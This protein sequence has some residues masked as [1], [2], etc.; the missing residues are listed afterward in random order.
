MGV[1]SE[2]LRGCVI[3]GADDGADADADPC[4]PG[5]SIDACLSMPSFTMKKLYF[6]MTNISSEEIDL[7]KKSYNRVV[8]NKEGG[9]PWNE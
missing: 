6:W 5:L 1:D 4:A 3:D 2:I 7:V 8:R 9:G